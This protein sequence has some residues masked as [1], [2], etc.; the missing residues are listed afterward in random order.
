MKGNNNP[1]KDSRTNLYSQSFSQPCPFLRMGFFISLHI[2]FIMGK[3]F[4]LTESEANDIRKMYGLLKEQ[5]SETPI[6]T[7]NGCFGKYTGP[8]FN[9]KGDIAHQYS[10]IITKA[11]ASKLKQLYSQGVYS[12]VDFSGIKMIT[13]GMG[14]GNVEFSINI[15]FIQVNDKC[16]AM[17]G[18][19]H[20]GGWNHSPELNNRKKELLNYIPLGKNENQILNNELFI[21]PLTKTPEGLQEYWIQWRHRDYQSDCVNS[22][23]QKQTQSSPQSSN[24]QITFHVDDDKTREGLDR[25]YEKFKKFVN[26][27]IEEAGTK[28]EF[29]EFNV[30]TTNKIHFGITL[31]PSDQGYTRMTIIFNQEGKPSESLNRVLEVNKN[32]NPKILTEGIIRG[33]LNEKT[34]RNENFEYYIIGFK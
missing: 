26:G 8:E 18:F 13:K 9:S 16:D 6:C 30:K 22:K 24:N 4:I 28:F 12:K 2:Y 34:G 29:K 11:V 27:K 14:S 19:A 17:T 32:R 10:N 20:V 3:R 21:S 1:S 25:L 33:V 31:V 5:I 7:K 23:S 15:P